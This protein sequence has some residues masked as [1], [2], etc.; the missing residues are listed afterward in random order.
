M[1]T[2]INNDPNSSVA[3]EMNFHGAWSADN[4]LYP[5]LVYKSATVR[6]EI[7]KNMAWRVTDGDLPTLVPLSPVGGAVSNAASP[8]PDL[9]RIAVR[10]SHGGYA[11]AQ[12]LDLPQSGLIRLSQTPGQKENLRLEAEI[13]TRV[14][15]DRRDGLHSIATADESVLYEAP[16]SPG[17]PQRHALGQFLGNH[18][19]NPI[20]YIEQPGGYLQLS[21]VKDPDDEMWCRLLLSIVMGEPP[22][23][24]HVISQ[25]YRPGTNP[26]TVAVIQDGDIGTTDSYFEFW[27][28]NSYK[29]GHYPISSPVFPFIRDGATQ[30]GIG[31]WPRGEG[32]SLYFHGDIFSIKVD[33]HGVCPC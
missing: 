16:A 11:A 21:E 17:E 23:Q 20:I 24:H 25:R 9:H 26:H 15:D 6:Q 18:Y 12:P 27:F 32:E 13:R 31:Y 2:E 22:E 29:I 8:D 4:G 14:D 33:P 1:M 28:Q 30:I 3:W 5:A 7:F 10:L 19:I